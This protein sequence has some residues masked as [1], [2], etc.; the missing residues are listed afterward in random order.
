MQELVSVVI[1][2]FNREKTIKRAIDSVLNQTYSN[3]EVIVVDDC[4]TDG[5]YTFI[6]KEYAGNYKVKIEKLP[7]NSGACVARNCGIELSKGE[8]IAFLDSDDAFYEDK[9]EVQIEALKKYQ[10]NLCATNYDRISENGRETKIT[11]RDLRGEALYNE[12]LFCNFITTGTLIGKR[13]CFEKIHFD[14]KLLRYQDWDLVLRLCKE[15]DFCFI[16]KSTLLQEFQQVSISSSTSHKKTYDSMQIIYS[17]NADG[18][19][20]CRRSE[21][22]FKWL[23]G[24]H[25]L[26]I[27]DNRR[28]D[29]LWEGV[30]GDG[31]K[32]KR[33]VVYLMA[34]F[35]LTNPIDRLFNLT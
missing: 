16:N 31:F 9:L 32:M 27:D 19:M 7:I 34:R 17:K 26:F 4:S 24:L 5:T 11:V 28:L 1:P 23:M 10:T 35:G 6:K 30:I 18:F 22:Q 2:S 8:Y 20:K 21:V 25:S 14:P 13:E 15:Y 29:Y 3:V 33:F 12:L